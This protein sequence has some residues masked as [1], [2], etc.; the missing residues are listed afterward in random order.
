MRELIPTLFDFAKLGGG[1]LL[2]QV[3]FMKFDAVDDTVKSISKVLAGFQATIGAACLILGVIFFLTPGCA[4]M[5]ISGI[6]AGLVL[7]GVSLKNIPA[8]GEALS[9]ASTVL[10][11]FSVPI[12]LAAL[13]S[14][15]FGLF[16]IMCI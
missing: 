5:D 12:G 2:A 3:V 1:L 15:F 4:L 11:G 9:K 10:K 16:N 6:L 14:G 7:L 13:A 8:V